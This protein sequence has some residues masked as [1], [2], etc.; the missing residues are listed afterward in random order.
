MSGQNKDQFV[1]VV[2]VMPQ[3]VWPDDE[4]PGRRRSA[5]ARVALERRAAEPCPPPNRLA[6]AHLV[7]YSTAASITSRLNHRRKML[8]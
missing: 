8:C 6:V 1:V 4:Q 3:L 5:V 7:R 2:A